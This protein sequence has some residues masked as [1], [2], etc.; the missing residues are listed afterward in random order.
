MSA[1][2]R[3]LHFFD[4]SALVKR[5]HQE[6]GTDP[7]DAVFDEKSAINIISDISVKRVR[8]S[9]HQPEPV[10]RPDE[11][12]STASRAH[13]QTLLSLRPIFPTASENDEHTSA[14]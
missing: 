8:A 4:T 11:Q 9:L 6:A 12:K 2:E 7:I 14:G 5:Y 10:L 3:E 1:A 13:K